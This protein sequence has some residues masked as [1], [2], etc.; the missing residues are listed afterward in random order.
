MSEERDGLGLPLLISLALAVAFLLWAL[1]QPT[2]DDAARLADSLGPDSTHIVWAG[3]L[4]ASGSVPRH[5]LPAPESPRPST[6]ALLAGRAC[7]ELRELLRNRPIPSD[8]DFGYSKPI[9]CGREGGG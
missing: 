5:T 3:P 2:G 1:A 8:G 7:I 9:V 6:S 4:L